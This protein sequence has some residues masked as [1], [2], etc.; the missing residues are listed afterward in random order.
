VY[1]KWN[2]AELLGEEIKGSYS[3]SCYSREVQNKPKP[4]FSKGKINPIREDKIYYFTSGRFGVAYVTKI[5]KNFTGSKWCLILKGSNSSA[6][7]ESFSKEVSDWTSRN[8]TSLY[9]YIF[10]ICYRS[11]ILSSGKTQLMRNLAWM[12]R[13]VKI[14]CHYAI[15]C[16]FGKV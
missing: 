11:V 15:I 6:V 8:G 5:L 16:F 14:W 9:S 10:F 1:V 3:I 7:A 12:S 13:F 4:F 2:E